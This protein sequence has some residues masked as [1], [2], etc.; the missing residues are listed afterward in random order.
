MTAASADAAVRR[1]HLAIAAAAVLFGSTFVVVR[2]AVDDV[3]PIPFL[4]VRF[5]VAGLVVAAFA[6]RRPS[7]PGSGRAGVV[8]GL[9]LAAGYV[10]Q[11]VG[12]Q[13][14]TSSVSAFIT[15]LLVVIVPVLSAVWLRSVPDTATIAG[16]ALAVGGL[17]LL[18][19]K[20]LALGRGEVLTVGCAVMFAVH[21]VLLAGYAP[22]FDV[23]RLNAVQLLVV[24]AV[25]SVPGL[26][27]GGYA[28][29]PGAVAAAVYTAI[30]ASAAAMALQLWGQRV[31]GATRTSLLLMVEPVAAA[32][33]GAVTGERLGWAGAAGAALI[34]AG[35]AV[36][37]V[38]L[39][40]LPMRKARLLPPRDA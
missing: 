27:S 34:L 10:L 12:L 26:W 9:A 11:T 8:V 6:C 33:L 38:P 40:T 24:G 20:G 2:D 14:T 37:E 36:A 32:V 3:E 17:Y 18:T 31:V 28:F 39:L 35:I 15:Y 23:V 21:I 29:T 22:R 1:A 7:S 16:V 30:A 25:C 19:G 5:T 13:Y 4:A